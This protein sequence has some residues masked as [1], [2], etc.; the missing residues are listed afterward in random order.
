MRSSTDGLV[1]EIWQ[2][3]AEEKMISFKVLDQQEVSFRRTTENR[4]SS[5]QSK[6]LDEAFAGFCAAEHRL[7]QASAQALETLLKEQNGVS[8]RMCW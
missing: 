2:K 7:G 5:L 8:A 4:R 1:E 6:T 3:C